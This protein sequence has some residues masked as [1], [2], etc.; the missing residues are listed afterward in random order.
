MSSPSNWQKCSPHMVCFVEHKNLSV[1]RSAVR[2]C[3]GLGVCTCRRWGLRWIVRRWSFTIPTSAG[4]R[5]RAY[6]H[7]HQEKT[8]ACT[9][10]HIKPYSCECDVHTTLMAGR[11]SH[12]RCIKVSAETT[13][14]PS[15]CQHGTDF[16]L[17]SS[18]KQAGFY[19]DFRPR[20]QCCVQICLW[21]V[22]VTV[23]VITRYI[24]V[25]LV[26]GC[27]ANRDTSFK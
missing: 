4:C 19:L 1:I 3:R 17:S 24:I 13:Y 20:G 23:H 6:L 10:K 26:H 25:I 16:V 9:P 22:S 15:V 27:I 2:T 12:Y 14:Y 8:Q 5:T 7:R 21:L 11:D 18:D